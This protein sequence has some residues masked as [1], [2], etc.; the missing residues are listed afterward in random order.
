MSQREFLLVDISNSFTKLAFSSRG[1]LG[2]IERIPTA[3][4]AADTSEMFSELSD[5]ALQAQLGCAQAF[6]ASLQGR[7]DEA[8]ARREALASASASALAISSRAMS[9]MS[10]SASISCAA[11]RSASHR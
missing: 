4:L 6:V 8:T 2:R 5:P 11:A 10:G 7:R 1:R 9:A 3:T